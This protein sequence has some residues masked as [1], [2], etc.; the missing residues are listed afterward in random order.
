MSYLNKISIVINSDDSIT[1]SSKK[2]YIKHLNNLFK[3]LNSNKITD[4]NNNEKIIEFI[5]SKFD[6]L[7][8]KKAFIN[9]I[10]KYLSLKKANKTIISNYKNYSDKLNKEIRENYKNNKITE[11]NFIHY[12]ELLKIPD[13]INIDSLKGLVDWFFIWLTINFPKRL[14]YYNL[15]IEKYNINKEYNYVDYKDIDTLHFYF[16]D[17]KNIKSFGKYDFIIKSPEVEIY[18]EKLKELYN[19]DVKYLYLNY[20][21]NKIT[22]FKSKDEY[23]KNIKN[24]IYNII[25][26][27]VNNTII[28]RSYTSYIMEREDYKH[29]TNDEKEKIHNK[30]LH[31]YNTA[32][33]IYNKV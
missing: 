33:S 15:P 23:S 11:D 9:S 32:N 24:I 7:N 28:R 14:D 5:E 8:T 3:N 2:L 16:N 19:D 18:M 25:G 13:M 22:N 20:K 27:K 12:E 29:L 17:F 21:D 26:K 10:L 6:N 1:E 4:L 30:L 31:T